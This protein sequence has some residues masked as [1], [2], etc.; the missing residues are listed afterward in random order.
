[1]TSRIYLYAEVL[2]NIRQVTLY[3]S[4]QTERNE[5]TRVDITSDKQTVSVTHD[6]QTASIF[7]PTAVSGSAKVT[8]PVARAKELSARLEIGASPGEHYKIDTVDDEVPWPATSLTNSTKLCCSQCHNVIYAA[9]EGSTWL[10]LPS[11]NWAEMMDFWHCHKPYDNHHGE[12]TASSKGYGASSKARATKGTGLVDILSFLCAKSDCVG[13]K[14]SL[15]SLLDPF[16]GAILR[17]EL[18]SAQPLACGQ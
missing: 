7:L 18:S 6:G 4:L 5:E 13:A 1:M 14:V 2:A 17:L 11:E 8:I 12:D 15:L 3:A 16:S 9:T 10:D